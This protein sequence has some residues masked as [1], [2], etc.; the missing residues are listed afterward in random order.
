VK[1]NLARLARLRPAPRLQRWQSLTLAAAAVVTAALAGPVLS[2]GGAQA[3]TLASGAAGAATACTGGVSVTQ[4]AFNP[5]SVPLGSASALTL[6]LQ[7][8]TSQP[9][10]G[11]T[12][13]FGTY[14]GQGCPVLDAISFPY[15]IA[16]GGSYT[17]TNRFG[18]P[19]FA[20]CQPTSLRMSANV[21]VNGAGTVTTV[22]ATLQ[23]SAVCTNGIAI[24]QFSFSPASVPVGQTSTLTLV[25]QNCTGQ[26]IQGSTIWRSAFTP[27]GTAPPPGCPVLDPVSLSYSIAPGGTATLTLGLGDPIASCQATGIQ[28]TVNVSVNGVTGT[29]ATATAFLV[30]THPATGG[31]HVTYTAN[32]WQG[33]FTADVAINNTG[34][35]P[36]NGWTLT[37]TFPGD[38]KITSAWNATVTQTGASVTATN[39]SYNATI[40]PG[41]SQWFGFQGTWATSNAAPASFSVNGMAC[42]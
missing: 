9:V 39:L 24:N 17:L 11:S 37:F 14:A 30:I 7:N 22:S 1:A 21:N 16:A 34:P 23:F 5:P 8:C 13:W 10:Q 35:S 31:C 4:F 27:A 40:S 41:G 3:A 33:G 12:A 42:T 32:S 6:V 29:A 20:G 2:A 15:T 28:A 19:G 38:Q 18:D 25:L 36:I 26:A